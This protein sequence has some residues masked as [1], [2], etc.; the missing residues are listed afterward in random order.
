MLVV[1]AVAVA[2]SVAL[3]SVYCSLGQ[4]GAR[5]FGCRIYVAWDG[6]WVFGCRGF[7]KGIQVLFSC[8]LDQ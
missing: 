6:V 7:E 5:G 8:P 4:D 1:V 3:S 2:L